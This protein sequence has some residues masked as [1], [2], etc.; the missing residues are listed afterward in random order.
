MW[1][2]TSLSAGLLSSAAFVVATG[3]QESPPAPGARVLGE[4]G[5]GSV[6]QQTYTNDY[7]GLKITF[8]DEWYIQSREEFDELSQTGAEA[9][10]GSDKN[11]K[12]AV[13]AALAMTLNLVSAFEHPPGTPGLFNSNIGVVAE[14]VKHLPGIKSGAEYLEITKQMLANAPLNYQFDAIEPNQKIGSL[15]A[16]C[17]PTHLQVGPQLVR[18]RYYAARHRD[19]VLVIITSYG[20]D[21]QLKKIEEILSQVLAGGE[22]ANDG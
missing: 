13:D 8:P 2:R 7:F 14:R 10:T 21:E 15:P 6:S 1:I 16:H 17:L 9:I 3:C 12:V 5:A 4:I 20:T 22:R 11:L 19:Y 18:Q